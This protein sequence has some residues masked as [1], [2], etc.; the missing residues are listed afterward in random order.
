MDY[1]IRSWRKARCRHLNNVTKGEL[2]LFQSRF[3]ALHA[4]DVCNKRWPC[5]A[6]ASWDK[7]RCRTCSDAHLECGDD[8]LV[9]LHCGYVGC[10]NPISTRERMGLDRSGKH[11]QLHLTTVG[12]H[13]LAAHA[14]RLDLYC[15]HCGDFFSD[16]RFQRACVSPLV[17]LSLSLHVSSLA[18][19]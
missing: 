4:S 19:H 6:N 5:E 14:D 12:T 9:C 3:N 16:A 1:N 8:M 17:T 11:G 13:W 18:R 15:S 7:N 10:W 2:A